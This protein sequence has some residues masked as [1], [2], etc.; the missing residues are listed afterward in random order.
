MR[1]CQ[2]VETV[3]SEET[4]EVGVVA[5]IEDKVREHHSLRCLANP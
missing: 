1:V 5:N 4:I 2:M 3:A